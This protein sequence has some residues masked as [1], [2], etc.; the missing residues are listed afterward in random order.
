MAHILWRR[1]SL[2]GVEGEK[3]A[4]MTVSELLVPPSPVDWRLYDHECLM[5]WKTAAEVQ[6][7]AE[8]ELVILA[9]RGDEQPTRGPR[10]AVKYLGLSK[11]PGLVPILTAEL[12]AD[13]TKKVGLVFETR[14]VGMALREQLKAF[15]PILLFQGTPDAQRAKR[16]TDFTTKGWCRVALV[17]SQAVGSL[18]IERP[19]DI[20]FVELPTD[21]W[22]AASLASVPRPMRLVLL[23]GT[24]DE[25]LM[26]AR[27]AATAAVMVSA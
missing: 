9:Q 22:W 11:L 23:A 1:L 27:W 13:R 26:R 17:A 24:V 14:D 7:L 12:H 21:P 3:G 16:L 25:A 15:N 20:V 6:A 5:G 8:E 4:T 10:H 18:P 19:C 2:A